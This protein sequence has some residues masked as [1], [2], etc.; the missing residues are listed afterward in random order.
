M[1]ILTRAFDYWVDLRERDVKHYRAEKERVVDIL[2]D[3]LE[4]IIPGIKNQIVEIDLSTP[5]TVNR[6][7]ANWKGS[8]E[9]WIL[10]PK[11]GFLQMKKEI[12]GLK[13]LYLAGHWVEPGGGLPAALLS[14]RNLAQIITH[15]DK[16][17]FLTKK[18]TN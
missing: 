12:K 6:Y 15:R 10:T 16:K 1:M 13:N 18:S 11:L 14:G 17:K 7:T 5:A 9:G 8:F 3:N 2:I 4:Q